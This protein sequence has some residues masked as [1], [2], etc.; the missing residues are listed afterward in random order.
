[1]SLKSEGNSRLIDFFSEFSESSSLGLILD[2]KDVRFDRPQPLDSTYIVYRVTAHIEALVAPPRGVP[3][4]AFEVT[5][6]S[7]R[8]TYN[9]YEPV[10]LNI[11]STKSGYLT[12]LD[13][14]GDSLT[15]LFPNEIDRKNY[16]AANS[17]FVFPPS[18]AYSLELE[19]ERG[20]SS[21]SDVL[22]AVVTKDDVPFP[23]IDTLR[24]EGSK[25]LVAEKSLTAF[26]NW[27][28][29]IPLDRRRADRK[30]IQIEKATN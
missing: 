13:I 25:L 3:D 18:K 8:S 10:T 11:R 19:T 6:T 27:L 2:E 28:Y 5:L 22:I 15:V 9:E 4:P 23:N 26:A 20:Q 1:M 30:A 12:I 24:L 17:D 7:R 14:H 29:R 21:S 16:I